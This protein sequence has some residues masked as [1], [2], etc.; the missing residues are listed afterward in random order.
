MRRLSRSSALSVASI[1]EEDMYMLERT[2]C[3][4]ATACNFCILICK[5]IGSVGLI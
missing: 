1:K 5:T 2:Q 4:E 3:C